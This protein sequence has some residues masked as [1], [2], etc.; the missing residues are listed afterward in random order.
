MH[1]HA[2]KG[3]NYHRYH[4]HQHHNHHRNPIVTAVVPQHTS[5]HNQARGGMGR[6]G[7]EHVIRS[8]VSGDAQTWH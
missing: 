7:Q 4:N 2:R 8:Q 3:R 1:H 5:V 6:Q